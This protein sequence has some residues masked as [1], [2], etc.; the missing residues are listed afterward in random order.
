MRLQK[1]FNLRTLTMTLVIG[2]LVLSISG[3]GLVPKMYF[4]DS[5]RTQFMIDYWAP[6]GT[7]IQRASISL[8][9]CTL[10]QSPT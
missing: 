2:L 3:F 4:P 1:M 6:Q 9:P 5:S 10:W 7:P 8:V